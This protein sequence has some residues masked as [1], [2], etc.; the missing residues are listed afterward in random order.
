[1]VCNDFGRIFVHFRL[2]TATDSLREGSNLEDPQTP[3]TITSEYRTSETVGQ[4]F[5]EIFERPFLGVS[6]KNFSI[7][8]KNVVYLP[9][10]L[11]TFFSHRPFSCFNV[12]FFRRG[13]K[14][15]TDIDTGGQNPY[16]STNSQCYHYSFRSAPEGAKL[17]WQFRWGAM[18]GFAPP[19]DPPLNTIALET[20]H[21]FHPDNWNHRVVPFEC[22]GRPAQ[23]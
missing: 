5:A 11:M 14:S 23:K 4:I 8:P 7:S 16:I 19:R 21:L 12:L 17:H 15:V 10:F 6:R 3:N 2:I 13:A 20:A 9:K 22:I 1:M 18:A